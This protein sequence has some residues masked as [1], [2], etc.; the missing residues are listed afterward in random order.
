MRSKV[1]SKLTKPHFM[2]LCNLMNCKGGCNYKPSRNCVAWIT[3][4]PFKRK[5]LEIKYKKQEKQND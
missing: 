5:L 2:E 3:I 4:D 1:R